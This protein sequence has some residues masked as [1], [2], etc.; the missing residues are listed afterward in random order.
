MR[1]IV[2]RYFLKVMVTGHVVKSGLK[3]LHYVMALLFSHYL[4][5]RLKPETFVK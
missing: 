3:T 1:N 5:E 2:N 4:M